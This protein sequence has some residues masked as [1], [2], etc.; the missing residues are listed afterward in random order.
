M[1]R[2]SCA[3]SNKEGPRRDRILEALRKAGLK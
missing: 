2:Q 1:G 3:S